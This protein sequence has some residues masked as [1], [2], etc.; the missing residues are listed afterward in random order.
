MGT[1]L[2]GSGPSEPHPQRV[3]TKGVRLCLGLSLC[4]PEK[5]LQGHEIMKAKHM[6]AY[7]V[8]PEDKKK[9]T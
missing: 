7:E 5:N 9:K 1:G 6:D 4:W 2:L 8:S 3:F